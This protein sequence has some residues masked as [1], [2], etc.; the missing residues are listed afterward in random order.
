MNCEICGS[1][2]TLVDIDH[3]AWRYACN[4]PN[5]PQIPAARR[6]EFWADAAYWD[7]PECK[8]TVDPLDA[9]FRWNGA[10]WEHYHKELFMW[11]GCNRERTND[12]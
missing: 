8:R 1:S 7:C 5:C 3:G 12:F 10:E 11:I 9:N 2:Q 4:N 6:P